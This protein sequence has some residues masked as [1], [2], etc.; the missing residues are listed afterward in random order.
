MN[1]EHV[2]YPVVL[3]NA[4]CLICN[5]LHILVEHNAYH[6]NSSGARVAKI[7]GLLCTI[8]K[9]HYFSHRDILLTARPSNENIHSY[10]K[11]S[12]GEQLQ[13][14]L[15]GRVQNKNK[16]KVRTRIVWKL[17]TQ[18]SAAYILVAG[19][20]NSELSPLLFAPLAQSHVART[21]K[22]SVC[23]QNYIIYLPTDCERAMAWRDFIWIRRS[24]S[25]LLSRAAS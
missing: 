22:Q 4:P 16:I 21:E 18:R 11:L 25:F 6:Q 15:L 24:A 23:A 14:T 8:G 20:I 10:S 9:A 3:E 13:D 1:F 7:L 17:V 12:S 5:A 19:L 2:H